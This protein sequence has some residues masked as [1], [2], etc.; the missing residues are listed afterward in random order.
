MLTKGKGKAWCIVAVRKDRFADF[1]IDSH[2]DKLRNDKLSTYGEIVVSGDGLYPPDDV[3]AKVAKLYRCDAE[4]L[5][6]QFQL[7]RRPDDPEA[8]RRADA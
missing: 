4:A 2:T 3:I 6:L 8:Q 1:V 7:N 5:L